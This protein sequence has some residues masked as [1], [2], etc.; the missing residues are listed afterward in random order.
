MIGTE[1]GDKPREKIDMRSYRR[2]QSATTTAGGWLAFVC[3][4]YSCVIIQHEMRYMNLQYTLG[5]LECRHRTHT[6]H[7]ATHKN[8]LCRGMYRYLF[9]FTI[10]TRKRKFPSRRRRLIQSLSIN[11]H[12]NQSIPSG[13]QPISPLA[14]NDTNLHE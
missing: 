12:Y 8:P 14:S 11:L 6:T 4:S 9:V 5:Q 1:N 3:P 13:P 10:I 2:T 7:S